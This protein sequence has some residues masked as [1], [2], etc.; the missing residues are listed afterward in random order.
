MMSTR[1]PILALS[2]L[3]AFASSPSTGSANASPTASRSDD[4]IL[5]TLIQVKSSYKAKRFDDAEIALRQLN[6]LLTAPEREAVRPRVLPV[7]HFYAAAVAWEKKDEPRAKEELQRFLSFQPDAE[8]DPAAYPK[9]FRIFFDAQRTEYARH[10][11]AAPNGPQTIAGGAL[12]AYSTHDADLRA[13]PVNTG[14]EDWVESPV[15]FLLTDDDKRAY[16]GL[17]DAEGRRTFVDQFWRRLNPN[18]NSVDNEVQ[19]EFYRRVQYADANFSTEQTKGSLTDRGMVLLVLGPPTYAG[20]TGLKR[21]SDVMNYLRTT[22]VVSIPSLTGGAV[23]QRV[24]SNR[25]SVTPGEIEG[26]VETWYYRRDRIPPGL[27]FNELEYQFITRRGYGSAVLQKEARELT[28]L[29]KAARLM[30]REK[31]PE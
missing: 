11:P 10:A 24:P 31:S 2:I 13:I 28:A 21:S 19:I 5:V 16:R 20:R 17:S 8:V 9:S 25:A 22:E 29:K 26:E 12:P 18:P 30:K 3:A 23:L 6:E 4:P 14:T 7:Y 15:R 27:A 1:T